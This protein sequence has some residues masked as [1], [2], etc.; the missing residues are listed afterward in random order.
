MREIDRKMS[1]IVDAES[2]QMF[3]ELR[4]VTGVDP[5][6]YADFRV[7][8]FLQQCV[9][10]NGPGKAVKIERKCIARVDTFDNFI[11]LRKVG[12]IGDGLHRLLRGLTATL[13]NHPGTSVY[14]LL[15]QTLAPTKKKD[16]T[17]YFHRA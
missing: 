3:E 6:Q 2:R 10:P 17:R 9:H 13:V 4:L 15:N 11:L 12:R 8:Q 16:H 14:M 7:L 1:E 5:Q